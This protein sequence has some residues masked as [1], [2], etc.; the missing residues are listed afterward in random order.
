MFEATDRVGGRLY[1]HKFDGFER[2]HAME[3]GGMRITKSMR[4]IHGLAKELKI[5]LTPLNTSTIFNHLRR[6]TIMNEE[7]I[8]GAAPYNVSKE[9]RRQNAGEILG[10]IQNRAFGAKNIA[11]A[12]K[13]LNEGTCWDFDEHLDNMKYRPTGQK[14]AEVDLSAMILEG[15]DIESKPSAISWLS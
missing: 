1:S 11:K 14:S 5:P 8:E 15:S 12:R 10:K 13:A 7:W 4:L 3:F 9:Y 6:K 2:E